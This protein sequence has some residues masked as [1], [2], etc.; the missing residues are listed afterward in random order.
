MQ[1]MLNDP[2]YECSPV[3]FNIYKVD[4]ADEIELISDGDLFRRWG[5][6][7]INHCDEHFSD[8]EDGK[9]LIEVSVCWNKYRYPLVLNY[10]S[11]NHVGVE[12]VD[13]IAGIK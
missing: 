10:Y 8:L 13:S 12:Q 1:Q 9:Y 6:Y 7:S 4:D 5:N 2:D 11:R 3:I